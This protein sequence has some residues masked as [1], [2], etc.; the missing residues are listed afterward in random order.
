MPGERIGTLEVAAS[1]AVAALESADDTP[2]FIL[3]RAYQAL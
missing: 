2:E 3:K 1:V